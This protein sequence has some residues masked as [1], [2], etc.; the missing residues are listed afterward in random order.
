MC[1]A[2]VNESVVVSRERFQMYNAAYR[3]LTL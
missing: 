1:S 3:Q 2:V